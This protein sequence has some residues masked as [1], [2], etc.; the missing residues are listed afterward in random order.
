M[1]SRAT[2]ENAYI[3]MSGR[4][5][6]DLIMGIA[7]ACVDCNISKHIRV[8]TEALKVPSLLNQHGVQ[9]RSGSAFIPQITSI[10]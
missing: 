2:L 10:N 6:Y 7:Y 4:N 9:G 3:S 8:Q 1:K 5:C